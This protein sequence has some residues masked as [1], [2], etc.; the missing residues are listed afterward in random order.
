MKAVYCKDTQNF[1]QFL[2]SL[3]RVNR[4]GAAE[5]GWLL[6]LGEPGLGKSRALSFY[7]VQQ[8]AVFLRAKAAWTVNWMLRELVT[9]IGEQPALRSEAL[10]DQ[11]IKFFA[12]NPERALVIDEVDHAMHDLRVLE[13]VRDLSDMTEITVVIGGMQG[14]ERKLK[15]HAHI[16]SRIADVCRFSPANIADTQAIFRALCEV[17][18]ADAVVAEAHRATG[19]YTREILNSIVE[20]ERLAKRNRIDCVTPEH[21]KGVRLTNDG[22]QTARG[23]A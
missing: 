2:A 17:E 13:S 18:V 19:G 15:R 4:R 10:L 1:Q 16:Y 3:L 7:A 5:A 23:A 14:V 20:I 8:N 11:A 12:M 6:V 9:E 21:L 22:R